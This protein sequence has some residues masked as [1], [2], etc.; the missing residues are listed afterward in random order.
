MRIFTFGCSFTQYHWPTWADILINEN[1][2]NG[3]IGENWGRQDYK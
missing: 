2:C 1:I 3:G